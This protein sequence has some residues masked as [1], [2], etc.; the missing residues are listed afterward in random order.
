MKM[1]LSI[2]GALILLGT[3]LTGCTPVQTN[4]VPYSQS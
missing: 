4:V 1:R 2:F 3:F